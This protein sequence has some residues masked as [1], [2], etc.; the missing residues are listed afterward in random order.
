MIMGLN[1]RRAKAQNSNEALEEGTKYLDQYIRAIV[2]TEDALFPTT[3]E[4]WKVRYI[5]DGCKP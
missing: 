4:F 1:G 3:N 5:R 2:V